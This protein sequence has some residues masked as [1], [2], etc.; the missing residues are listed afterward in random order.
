VEKSTLFRVRKLKLLTFFGAAPDF[1]ENCFRD[2][3]ARVIHPEGDDSWTEDILAGTG[4][5]LTLN[6]TAPAVLYGDADGSGKVDYL[7]AMTV[8]QH[9]VGLI[10]LEGDLLAA[11]DVDG[12]GKVDYLDAMTILQ[13]A[14]GLVELFPVEM[15]K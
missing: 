9:S 4:G 11:C 2:V 6:N 12:S 8:L 7:D 1:G 10:T 13:K 14:V 3:T 15:E 5:N